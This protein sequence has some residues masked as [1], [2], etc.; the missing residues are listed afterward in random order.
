MLLPRVLEILHLCLVELGVFSF[1]LEIPG[2]RSNL[3][4][5]ISLMFLLHSKSMQGVYS[6]LWCKI[7]GKLSLRLPSVC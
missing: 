2:Q 3:V 4:V 5:A 6:T 7:V 1:P